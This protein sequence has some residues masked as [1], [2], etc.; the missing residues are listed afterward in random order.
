MVI[1]FLPATLQRIDYARRRIMGW[2]QQMP[3][4]LWLTLNVLRVL[5]VVVFVLTIAAGL[6]GNQEP[7][8]NL[9]PTMIWIIWWV[10]VAFLCA[11]VGDL[12]KLL[13]PLR[14]IYLGG[15]WLSRRL[16]G[17]ALSLGVRYPRWLGAWPA[18]LLMFGFAWG[19]HLWVGASAPNGLALAMLG[20]SVFTLAAM[21]IFGGDVW[22][23]NGECFSVAFAVLARFA[24]FELRQPVTRDQCPNPHCGRRR[25]ACVNGLSCGHLSAAPERSLNV[26]LFG[27]GLLNDRPASASLVVF[28]LLLLSSVTF[29]GF[30]DTPLWQDFVARTIPNAESRTELAFM[31]ATLLAFPTAFVILF[32]FCGAVMSVIARMTVE[33]SVTATGPTRMTAQ[34]VMTLVPIAVAYHLAHYLTLL[35]TGGQL[36]V[37]LASD[38]FGWGW[39]LF[40][41]ADYRTVLGVIEVKTV[42]KLMVITIVAGHVLSVYLAHLVALDVCKSKRA[43]VRTEIPLLILMVLYTMVSLWILAQPVYD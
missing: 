19:E 5:A 14:S 34:F 4:S 39:N 20:Y 40:G 21:S 26:R 6:L 38:P 33:P 2:G 29:D 12:W 43:A 42:W 16:R 36:I 1:D 3:P 27:V 11:L 30:V 7:T 28:V 35:L 10:G 8:R 15:D 18:V 37:P 24:P 25:E 32:A 22:L 13:N 23:E 31:T 9:A 17:R 41:T